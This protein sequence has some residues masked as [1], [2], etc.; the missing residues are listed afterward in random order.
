MKYYIT[1]KYLHSCYN[2][3]LYFTLLGGGSGFL[4]GTQKNCHATEI[5]YWYAPLSL[6]IQI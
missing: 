2:L 3:Y 1:I 6:S 5:A 4:G